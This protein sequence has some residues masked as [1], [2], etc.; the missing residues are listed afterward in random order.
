MYLLNRF[1]SL[2]LGYRQ[3]T[4]QVPGHSD[5]EGEM[6][7]F[8]KITRLIDVAKRI[9]AQL[10]TSVGNNSCSTVKVITFQH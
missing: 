7:F 5:V 2:L 1:F 3:F 9:H 10:R 4:K 8:S 6:R